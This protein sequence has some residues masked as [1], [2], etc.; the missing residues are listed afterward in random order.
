MSKLFIN[1]NIYMDLF[2]A[3]IR[4][5]PCWTPGTGDGDSAGVRPRLSHV[6]QTQGMNLFQPTSSRSTLQ[7]DSVF[8]LNETPLSSLLWAT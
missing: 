3:G 8:N 2:K 6:L 4:G 5:A 1:S 7:L